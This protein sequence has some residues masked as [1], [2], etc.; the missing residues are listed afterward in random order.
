MPCPEGRIDQAEQTEPDEGHAGHQ[1]HLGRPGEMLAGG[2]EP[3]APQPRVGRRDEVAAQRRREHPGPGEVPAGLR[4]Q[5][6]HAEVDASH[7]QAHR[8]EEG[9]AAE[10]RGQQPPADPR[11]AAVPPPGPAAPPGHR[12]AGGDQEVREREADAEAETDLPGRDRP[13]GQ[14]PARTVR[15][16]PV[17][18]AQRP[19]VPARQHG[20]AQRDPA[21]GQHVEVPA[22]RQPP[23]REGPPDAG[24]DGSHP[25]RTQ[26]PYQ[27]IRPD[28]GERVRD[29][30]QDV[31]SKDRRLRTRAEPPGRCVAE[32]G[33]A[34]GEAVR[35]R[36]EGVGV[37][38]VRRIGEQRVPGPGDL[39]RLQRRIPQVTGD[40]GPGVAQ[41][42]PGERA[43]EHQ[44]GHAGQEP[45]VRKT[46]ASALRKP[47]PP[48]GVVHHLP[49][50]IASRGRGGRSRLCRQ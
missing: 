11:P 33:V 9:T 41:R 28:K 10:I 7:Q 2:G 31:V 26:L 48:A 30:V 43:G 16:G 37:P 3:V 23:R 1:R 45:L 34:V 19:A 20:Q 44:R 12:Q 25:A 24:D 50:S 49:S 15:A 13:A 39:P 17:A 14:G 21:G 8:A 18:A 36:E 29:D 32:Q 27:G 6:D 46:S 47:C 22:V 42:G 40:R 4:V 35:R 38:Q 5:L